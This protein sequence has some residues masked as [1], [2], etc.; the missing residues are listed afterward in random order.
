MIKFENVTKT[1]GEQK[2]IDNFTVEIKKGCTYGLL[3]SNGAGKSTFLRLLSGVYRQDSGRITI[4]GEPV[5]DN[6]SL[7]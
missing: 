4:D 3:G 7:K 2:A 6:P 5:Y 1:F